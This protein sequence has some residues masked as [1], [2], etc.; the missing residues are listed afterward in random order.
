MGSGNSH[1][2]PQRDAISLSSLWFG[3]LGA[4]IAW[5]G[6][7][8]VSY[9]TSTALC[10]VDNPA[11]AA[12]PIATIGRA[13]LTINVLA[14]LLALVAAGVAVSNWRKTRHEM[15]GS[16]HRLLEAGEG[17]TRFLAMFGL[18]TSIG[19]LIA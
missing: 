16:A 1:P 11:I 9:I 19:F 3:I 6:L 13:L 14:G 10:P 5:I 12:A 17:R 4:P 18:L 2:L 15:S 7:E 8:L